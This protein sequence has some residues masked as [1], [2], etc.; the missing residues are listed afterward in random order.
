MSNPSVETAKNIAKRHGKDMVIVLY[1]TDERYGYASYGKNPRLCDRV[2]IV[3]DH[4]ADLIEKG[5]LIR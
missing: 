2:R 3:A 5:H 4:I 1:F